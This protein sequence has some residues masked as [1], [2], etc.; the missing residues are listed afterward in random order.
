VRA[1]IRCQNQIL[2][3][4]FLGVA[5]YL[6][7]PLWPYS[8]QVQVT[9]DD[10]PPAIV[11]LRDY[12]VPFSPQEGGETAPFRVVWSMMGL[13]NTVHTM[14]IGLPRIDG[15]YAVVDGIMCAISYTVLEL[16]LTRL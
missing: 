13:D 6:L 14:K 8:V 5:V 4:V 16:L 12:S 1:V 11:D 7:S 15:R 9:L 2:L 3:N 10:N